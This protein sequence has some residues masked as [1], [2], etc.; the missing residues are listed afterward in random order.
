MARKKWEIDLKA[1]RDILRLASEERYTYREIGT[2]LSVSHQTVSKH[3]NTVARCGLDIAQALELSDQELKEILYPKVPG[4]ISKGKVTP[5]FNAL[6]KEMAKHPSLTRKVLWDEYK[7]QFGDQSYSYSQFCVMMSSLKKVNSLTMHLEHSPGDKLFIDFGGDKVPIYGSTTSDDVVF[8]ASIFVGV[9]AYSG[10]CYVRAY[11]HQ[12][13]PSVIDACERAF[14]DFGGVTQRIVPDNMKAAVI[15]AKGDHRALKLNPSFLEFA[16]FVGALVVPTRVKRP[17]DK[18]RVEQMVG[19]VQRE[20]ISRIRHRH[21]VN[22]AELNEELTI[23]CKH[24]NETNFQGMN[25]SRRN[26]FLEFERS[27]LGPL[28]G[29]RFEFGI[30]TKATATSS[31]HVRVA[32][33]FYSVPYVYA[34]RSL[35]VKMT[36]G[37][38][39]IYH[40][41]DCVAIHQRTNVE[42]HYVTVDAHMPAPHRHYARSNSAATMM[43]EIEAIGPNSTLFAQQILQRTNGRGSAYASI[44][45]ILDIARRYS[46]QECE[47]SVAHALRIGATKSS[48]VLNIA[49]GSLYLYNEQDDITAPN[50]V[51]ENIR[52]QHYYGGQDV[53]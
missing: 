39:E 31:Y 45:Q 21:L 29:K 14:I 50:P 30:W 7:E 37:T 42:N 12:D 2:S 5:D 25:H 34:N 38:V 44:A 8:E 26:R 10:M 43:K 22:L 19:Y 35:S 1:I 36:L 40:G 33:S 9:L 18:A 13:V 28:P 47:K 51:H 32:N 4:P 49:K 46:R 15:D 41:N 52:G 24:L 23:G 53:G 16:N 20:I 48:S 11:E 17:R 3:V 6:I 27:C